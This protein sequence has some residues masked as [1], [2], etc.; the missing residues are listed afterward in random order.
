VLASTPLVRGRATRGLPDALL[1]SLAPARGAAQ[2]AL[3]F[4]RSTPGVTT[5]LVGMRSTAHVEQ[6][7]ALARHAPAAPE[8]I[9]GLFARARAE[10]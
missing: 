4:A 1:Q 10:A 2:V 7:L 6:N 5:T 3:Q 9:E 8:V